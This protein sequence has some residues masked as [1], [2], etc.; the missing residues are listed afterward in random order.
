VNAHVRSIIVLSP[1]LSV[2]RQNLD[3]MGRS[4]P[5]CRSR[6]MKDSCK[7]LKEQMRKQDEEKRRKDGTM[8]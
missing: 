7:Q 3:I 2:G 5:N 4:L 8:L 1:V 6:H